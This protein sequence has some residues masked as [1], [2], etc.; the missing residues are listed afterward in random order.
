MKIARIIRQP[1]T[2]VD[3]AW[4]HMDNPTNLALICGVITFETQLD[5]NRLQRTLDERLSSYPRFKQR[6]REYRIGPPFWELDRNFNLNNHLFKVSL[7]EPGNH[8]TLQQM[9]SEMMSQ[10]L[11][12][13]KP[14]WEM[15]YVDNYEDRSALICRFHHCL[16]DGIALVQVLL[17]AADLEPDFQ[18]TGLADGDTGGIDPL[19]QIFVPVIKLSRRVQKTYK[20]TRKLLSYGFDLVTHPSHFQ[21]LA[22]KGLAGGEALGKLLLMPPDPKTILKEECGIPK[23]AVWSKSIK[24]SDVKKVGLATNATVNDVLMA[25][26]TGALQKYLVYRGHDV[27]GLNIRAIIPVN[28][29]TSVDL[30]NLGNNFGLVFLSLPLDFEDPFKRLTELKSRMDRIKETPEAVVAF[31]ILNFMGISPSIIEELIR[32]MFGKKGSVVVTNVPG[33]DVPLYLAGGK[34]D[35]L[36]FWVPTPANLSIGISIISFAGDVIIGIATDEGIIP[37]PERIIQGFMDE[38][39]Q[40][41]SKVDNRMLDDKLSLHPAM[42]GEIQDL[43]TDF[44]K[45]SLKITTGP[46]PRS[47][48]EPII[49]NLDRC[50]A[51]TKKG[52]R[53]KNQP[54]PGSQYCRVHAMGVNKESI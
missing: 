17:S 37:D 18:P 36:M 26:I 19:A 51:L 7:P 49:P 35:G 24:I 52:V 33:P 30:D 1:F 21:P 11:D 27:H 13:L 9:V 40:A 54:I 6:V 14:L 41:L 12:L 44:V 48:P 3:T 16:A 38:F 29:N 23:K 47:I 22:S 2:A 43:Q 8:I 25:S 4:L 32:E 53:C 45:Q 34:I 20:S 10:P 31:G 39:N 46:E 50:L 15:I 42:E 28:L 5:F